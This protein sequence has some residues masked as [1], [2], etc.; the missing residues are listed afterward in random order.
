MHSHIL[1]RYWPILVILISLRLIFWLGAFPNSDEAYYWLWGQHLDWSYFDHPPFH[2]WVQGA[3]AAVLGRSHFVLRLPNLITTGLLFRLYWMICYQLYGQQGRQ[4][5]WLTV[6]LVLTSPLFFLFLAM[7]WHDHWLVW[8]GTAASYCLIRF[9]SHDR[10]RSY[11]WLY[12]AGLL[13]GLAGLCK[14]VALFLGL[15]F[16]VVIAAHKSWRSLLW[17]GHL[18]GA[19]AL[20]F[21]VMTPVF[22]WNAHHEWASFQFY[23]GRSVQTEASTIQWFGPVGFGLLTGLIFGPVH[24]WL[25][26]QI[27][28]QK[29]TDAF[30]QAYQRVA[31]TIL[32]TSTILLAT[33][34]LIAPVLYYWNIL[35]YPLL[36]PLVAGRFLSPHRAARLRQRRLLH[37]ALAIGTIVATLLVIHYTFIPLSALLGETGDDDTRMLYGWPAI[38]ESIKREAAV[39]A[40]KPLLLTTDYRSAAALAYV[41]NDPSVLAISGR[42]DQFDFWYAPA[43]LDGRDG[44]LLG[45]E[46]HPI[47]PQHLEMF[48]QTTAPKTVPVEQ[49]NTFIKQYTIQPGRDFRAQG[50]MANPLSLNYPL[51]FTTDGETCTPSQMPTR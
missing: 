21:L 18:Y 44:L 24:L 32:V 45:D 42:I 2:A 29:F 25:T 50:A 38:A 8:F 27:T 16:L 34:S 43:Q 48:E 11:I 6:L 12:A 28:K 39:F 5:F 36:F 41:L 1:Q 13:I 7:A 9:L 3:F 33:L 26:L 37:I 49:L 17:N 14:Y 23:L 51:A 40:E 46:W 47:C 19:V 20:A 22:W 4:A 30:G 10:G 35:A 31:L 15:G